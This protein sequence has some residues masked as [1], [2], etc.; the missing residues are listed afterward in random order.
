MTMTISR[1]TVGYSN[2]TCPPPWASIP[3]NRAARMIP[4]GWLRPISAT[5][6]PTKPTPPVKFSRIRCC[7]PRISFTPTNPA[8]APEI[9]MASMMFFDGEMPA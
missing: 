2:D 1:F 7:T 8:S 6:I 4:T 5:A 3:N 9:S